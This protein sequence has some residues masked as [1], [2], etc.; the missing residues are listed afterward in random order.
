MPRSNV[1]VFTSS[2]RSLLSLIAP[3]MVNRS[4]VKQPN[5]PVTLTMAALLLLTPGPELEKLRRRSQ[6][7]VSSFMFIRSLEAWTFMSLNINLTVSAGLNTGTHLI[8]NITSSDYGLYRCTSENVAGKSTCELELYPGKLIALMILWIYKYIS[9]GNKGN[10]GRFSLLSVSGATD[11]G[12]LDSN[13]AGYIAAIVLAVLLG[14][15]L[16]GVAIWFIVQ[17]VNKKKYKGVQQAEGTPMRWNINS[18]NC[19]FCFN[20]FVT[21]STFIIYSSSNP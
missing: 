13:D 19:S 4:W 2:Q 18:L 10:T 7:S 20:Y 3:S 5:S 12:K 1:I 17:A 9:K 6:L 16:I 15:V 8:E 11:K 21:R 14:C